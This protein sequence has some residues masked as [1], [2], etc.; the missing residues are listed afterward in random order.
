MGVL[1]A[2]DHGIDRF[3]TVLLNYDMSWHKNAKGQTISGNLDEAGFYAPDLLANVFGSIA[4]RTS[5]DVYGVGMTL[6]YVYT[7]KAP[8]AG[9]SKSLDWQIM[10]NSLFKPDHKI[11][12]RSSGEFLKRLV[13]RA[14]HQDESSRITLQNLRSRLHSISNAVRG[15]YSELTADVWAEELLSRS[16]MADYIANQSETS[17]SR[18]LKAGRMITCKG[19]L[20]RKRVEI[21]FNNIATESTDRQRAARSWGEKLRSSQEILRSG[22]WKIGSETV[23]RD[24]NI[25]LSAT[26]D[27]ENISHDFDRIVRVLNRGLDQIKLD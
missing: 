3:E 17:F 22:G 15:N 9:G 8:P 19:D 1:E 25:L 14:T 7:G 18:Q 5:V 23:Y 2:A 16:I 6:F 11:K 13:M 4:R 27:V 24:L 10:L 12:W 21:T 26:V 20:Q